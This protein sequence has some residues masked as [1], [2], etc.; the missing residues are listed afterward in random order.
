MKI[1]S[2][3]VLIMSALALAACGGGGGG[4]KPSKTVVVPGAEG[5]EGA[6]VTISDPELIKDQEAVA[7]VSK[8]A[9]GNADF[10]QE[11]NDKKPEVVVAELA[12][13]AVAS[14]N[15]TISSSVG[16]PE[17]KVDLG[18]TTK[19]RLYVGDLGEDVQ[20]AVNQA[21]SVADEGSV[22]AVPTES[23][24][25]LVKAIANLGPQY[26]I[27]DRMIRLVGETGQK[28][29]RAY[30]IYNQQYSTVTAYMG[31]NAYAANGTKIGGNMGTVFKFDEA[32][33]LVGTAATTDAIKARTAPV[34]YT[35][36]AFDKEGTNGKFTYTINFG[37]A[38]VT[39]KGSITGLTKGSVT[40]A[41][42]ALKAHNIQGDAT[43]AYV[44]KYNLNVYGPKAEEVA[45][46]IKNATGTQ[47]FVGFG[48]TAPAN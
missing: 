44:G 18:D 13:D 9:G 14:L 27:E 25:A 35:G 21:T 48:G 33:G 32:N 22:Q 4:G 6:K 5:T 34:T 28:V 29:E 31:Q 37:S 1:K 10:A 26:Q 3:S 20:A 16:N 41:E 39:G 17:A 7:A 38:N 43:G 23:K 36:K 40:L 45:G 24:A 11:L 12:S 42:A 46:T 2:L 47:S 19:V 30:R 8:L 15:E